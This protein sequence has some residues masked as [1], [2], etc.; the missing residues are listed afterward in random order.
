MI[1]KSVTMKSCIGKCAIAERDLQNHYGVIAKGSEVMIT[2][3]NSYGMQVRTPTCQCCGVS[4]RM[5]N[6]GRT[7]LTILEADNG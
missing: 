5:T 1:P 4:L 6:V 3:S 7:D 2:G